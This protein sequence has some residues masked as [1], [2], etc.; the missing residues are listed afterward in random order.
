MDSAL[1]NSCHRE[2]G[3]GK[4]REGKREERKDRERE[5]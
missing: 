1:V 3:L 2:R 5:G 4:R